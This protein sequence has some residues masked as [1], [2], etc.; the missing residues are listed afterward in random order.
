MMA[1]MIFCHLA[2][3]QLVVS[4]HFPLCH[5]LL[6]SVSM[7]WEWLLALYLQKFKINAV[8]YEV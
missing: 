7:K 2:S 6:K 5:M 1:V 3:V 4:L 8:M